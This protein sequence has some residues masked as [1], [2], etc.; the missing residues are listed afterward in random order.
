MAHA[1]FRPPDYLSLQGNVAENW[2]SWYQQFHNFLTAKE[3][4]HKSD[5]VKIAMLLNC[6]GPE[7]LERYNNFEFTGEEGRT[8]YATVIQ[9]FERHYGI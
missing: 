7:S 9:K 8:S 1:D 5:T 2:K 3:A 6:L 4:D